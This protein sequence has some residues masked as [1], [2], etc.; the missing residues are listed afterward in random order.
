MEPLQRAT[1]RGRRDGE[2]PEE[3]GMVDWDAAW[4]A[5]LEERPPRGGRGEWDQ[6]AESFARH[7]ADSDYAERLLR[8]MQPQRSWT[9]LD[10]GCGAGTVA[11]PLARRVASV[12]AL[13]FSPRMIELL[14]LRCAEERI[15]N[16]ETVVGSWEDDWENLKIGTH[17]VALAS[18]SLAVK[19]LRAAVIKL[20]RAAR[21]RVFISSLVGD[22]PADRR[23]FEAV[24]RP[25][26]RGPDY[27][28][29]YN[30]LHD[31]EIFANV[32]LLS[33]VEWKRYATHEEALENLRWMLRNPTPEELDRLKAYL[34]AQLVPHEGGWRLPA[35]RTVRWAV[36]WWDK[37]GEPPV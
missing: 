3:A 15:D 29:V 20:D 8:I 16:V 27:I 36:I 9:V 14:R 19:E 31:M 35:P 2:E 10:V 6:R 5:A 37:D 7:V 25:L 22:G 1:G 11:V 33:S 21:R 4:K 28:Y 26:H 23:I 13:D 18:R 24:G 34:A 32:S 30:L 17:D 12:T